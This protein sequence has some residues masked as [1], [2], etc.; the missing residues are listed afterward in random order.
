VTNK[1]SNHFFGV[2]LPIH[3]HLGT[4]HLTC[5]EGGLWFSV[6]FRIFFSD[7]TRVRIFF[8]CRAKREIFSQ[9][10]TLDYMTKI[11]NQIIFFSSTKIGIFFSATLG[12][13]IL[14]FRNKPIFMYSCRWLLCFCIFFQSVTNTDFSF[15]IGIEPRLIRRSYL[16]HF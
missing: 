15:D 7:N 4:D 13:R 5:R 14:F 12:I 11:L 16:N 2:S 9:N 6:L 3:L 10:K 8:F 1:I